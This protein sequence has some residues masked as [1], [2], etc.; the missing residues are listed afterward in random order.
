MTKTISTKSQTSSPV[1]P[2]IAWIDLLKTISI[3]SVVLC[4]CTGYIANY[5]LPEGNFWFY[6]FYA[7]RSITAVCVPLFF[8]VNGFLLLRHPFDLKRH[9]QKILKFFLIALF[10]YIITLAFLLFLHRSE[11]SG[12]LTDKISSLKYGITHLWYLGA[13]VC[14]YIF[15]PLL[16]VVY[17]HHR[18]VFIY[19][20]IICTLITFGNTLLNNLLTFISYF[21][22]HQGTIYTDTN[23][24]NIFNPFRGIYGYTFAY[25]CLGGV[26]AYYYNQITSITSKKRNL[27]AVAGL[28]FGWLGLFGTGMLYSVASGQVWDNIWYSYDTI[29][30]LITTFAIFFLCLN[31]RRDSKLLRTISR[32]TLGI[33]LIHML[34]IYTFMTLTGN[35]VSQYLSPLSSTSFILVLLGNLLYASLIILLSLA[36]TLIFKKIP[37]IKRLVS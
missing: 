14:L 16:K 21:F 15:F 9:L 27:F 7:L 13:L 10:W 35:F 11:L 20:T 6:L 32:N 4:H 33:Y 31:W 34:I 22:L 12:S 24:L 30:A 26:V 1:K 23:F 19:F 5:V 29:F 17:D 2:R 3:F 36:V 37:L 25:F 18:K 28:V 8:F